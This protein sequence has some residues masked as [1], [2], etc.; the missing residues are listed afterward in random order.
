MSPATFNSIMNGEMEFGESMTLDQLIDDVEF[1]E[2]INNW[3]VE[4]ED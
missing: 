3:E 2:D 1:Q 4:H